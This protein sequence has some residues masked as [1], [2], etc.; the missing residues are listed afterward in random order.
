MSRAPLPVPVV[1]ALCAIGAAA[2]F[3][4][5]D[6]AVKSLSDRYPLHEVVLFRSLIGLALVVFVVMPLAGGWSLMR[7]RRLGMH[8][9]RGGFVL[10]AN[11]VFFT[12]LAVMPIAD[13]TAIFFV[14][15]LLIG[16]FSVVFLG[17]QVGIR[18]WSAI[19]AGLIG[20]LVMIRPGTDAFTV[21]ALL[22]LI[23]AMG[24][25]GLNVMT[26]SI[27][28]TERAP[29]M[30]FY[31]QLTF[32]VFS[33]GMGLGVGD[34]RFDPG[35]G[36]S[37]SFLLRAWTWPDSADLWFFLLAGFGTGFGGLLISQA[38]RLCEAGLIAP[39]E[40]IGMPLAIFW[41][42]VVFGE[43]PDAISWIGISLILA[44]GLYMILRET[45][46]K[47]A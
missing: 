2:C 46:Q 4:L 44:A 25:A 11:M 28:V 21:V 43:W 35:G 47:Q 20:A 10:F 16:V 40:Y 5:N 9:I 38:Y 41:G 36:G 31:I 30:A 27:G 23:A 6:M 22:P 32:V 7:T 33:L 45:R 1:G 17:E 13:A 29:T 18:R 15:P 37:L 14:S 26:R 42:V 8:L 34:G 24:Y 39:L 12:A 3:T 19:T